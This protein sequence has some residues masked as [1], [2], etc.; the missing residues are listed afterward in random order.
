MLEPGAQVSSVLFCRGHISL[1]LP[2][3][4]PGELVFTVLIPFTSPLEIVLVMQ[5][6][7]D[8]TPSR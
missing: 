5:T 8:R 1:H 2:L 6:T 3:V 7:T 4:Q